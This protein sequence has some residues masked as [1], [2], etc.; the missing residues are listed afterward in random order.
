MVLPRTFGINLTQSSS[1]YLQGNHQSSNQLDILTDSN[2]TI[3]KIGDGIDV[4]SDS[5]NNNIFGNTIATFSA[6]KIVSSTAAG[7]KI[8]QDST[9][10]NNIFSNN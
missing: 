1:R 8:N 10:K 7:L 5:S 9:A 2:K 4:R 6:N 3:S